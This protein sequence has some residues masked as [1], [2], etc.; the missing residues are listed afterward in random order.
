MDA[1]DLERTA[2]GRYLLPSAQKTP[3]G[4]P[5]F[6]MFL[7]EG[8]ENDPG[9]RILARLESQ[10][11]GYEFATRAFLDTHLEPGDIFVDIGAH[12][13]VYSLAAATAPKGGIKVLAIEPN[14]LN[15]ISLIRQLALN[16]RQMDVEV[17]AGAAGEAAGFGQLWPF[18]SMGNFISRERPKEAPSDNPPLTVPLIPL[19]L[20]FEGRDDLAEGRV[21]LKVDVE[22]Y[23]PETLSG[24]RRLLASGRVAAVILEKSDLYAPPDRWRA[25]EEMIEEIRGFGFSIRWFPHLNMPCAFIPWVAGNECGNLV[26]L[27]ADFTPLPAYDG[28]FAPYASRPPPM[29]AEVTDAER[30][31]LTEAL[32]KAGASDGWRWSDPKMLAAGSVERAKLAAPHLPKSGR[33]LDLGAGLM[34]AKRHLDDDADYTPVDLV[35]YAETTV[36]ADLN[37]GQFPA[38]E[39]DGVMA[40]EILE[41]IHDPAA[42]LA[43]ARA[44]ASRLVSTYRCTA[45]NEPEDS[46]R[47]AG[48][49]NDF[50][51]LGMEALLK[52]AGWSVATIEEHAPYTL[53]VAD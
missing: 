33:V 2:D 53:F 12:Y 41:Y 10:H 52:A 3:S 40:L 8:Y 16:G 5:R 37:E 44:G 7:L 22:G 34:A 17:V 20:L 25:F 42:L 51:R 15:V 19:D 27:A 14:P 28:P 48:Y 39:W 36:L 24:A 13:G 47:I 6:T 4:E 11:L 49:F 26:A 29:H 46:R 50:D 23:E 43:K 32:I 30:E 38:G 1:P 31:A 21:F 45:P 18:S 35:R 9:L